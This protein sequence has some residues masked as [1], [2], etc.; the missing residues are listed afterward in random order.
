VSNPTKCITT[1]FLV[2]AKDAMANEE[3]GFLALPYIT[4]TFKKA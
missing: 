3:S 4:G 1:K 2:K